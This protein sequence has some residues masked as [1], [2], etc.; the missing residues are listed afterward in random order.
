VIELEALNSVGKDLMRP[1]S[2]LCTEK[3]EIYVSD[4]RGGVTCIYPD[5]SQ[6]LFSGIAPDGRTLKPNGIALRSDRSFLIADL[7]P[8][9]GGIFHLTRDG[10]LRPFIER[11]DGV[12]LPPTNFF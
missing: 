5:G 7:S 11:V 9:I 6:K 4:L 12:D 10:A 2:I 1:E 3:G 8:E